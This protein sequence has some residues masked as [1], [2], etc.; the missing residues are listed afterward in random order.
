MSNP[1]EN[2]PVTTGAVQVPLLDL[3]RELATLAGPLKEAFA[4]VL[5][6][7]H[8][9]LGP[10]VEAFEEAAASYCGAR[11]ALGV[12][13]G[14]DALLLALACLWAT[15]NDF[16]WNESKAWIA[17]SFFKFRDC[18]NIFDRPF[19]HAF[20]TYKTRYSDH[21]FPHENISDTLCNI[22]V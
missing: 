19:A 7:G 5:H 16:A 2:K 3:K 4:R 10:E 17:I 15:Y 11:H 13:S 12:S 21:S 8:Y 6:S 18:S 22:I 14:S 9:I 20:E 1:Q